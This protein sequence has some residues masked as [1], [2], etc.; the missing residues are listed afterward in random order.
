ML[1][2]KKENMKN[3]TVFAACFCFIGIILG[4]IFHSMFIQTYPVGQKIYK[5]AVKIGYKNGAIDHSL[6]KISVIN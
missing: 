2:L 1:D 4:I 6:G 5:D 3:N